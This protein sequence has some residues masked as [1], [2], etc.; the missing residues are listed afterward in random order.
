MHSKL[1]S[2]LSDSFVEAMQ[3][4]LDAASRSYALALGRSEQ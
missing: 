4:R 2:M 1:N 3:R